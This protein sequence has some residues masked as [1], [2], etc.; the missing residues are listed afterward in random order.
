[1][2][3]EFINEMIDGADRE[4]DLISK[5]SKAAY[6]AMINYEA[7][8]TNQP[9]ETIEQWENI[10]LEQRNSVKRG[11]ASMLKHKRL[12]PENAHF[13][14]YD[15]MTKEGWSYG[16]AYNADRKEHPALLAWEDLSELQKTTHIIFH[17]VVRGFQHIVIR[18]MPEELHQMAADVKKVSDICWTLNVRLEHYKRESHR[19]SEKLFKEMEKHFPDEEEKSRNMEFSHEFGMVF[20]TE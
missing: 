9:V 17:S 12:T 18:D 4:N 11:I 10:S 13:E 8:A 5:I 7:M 16:P 3:P 6:Q 20:F 15:L 14:F 19:M 2:L 1:M